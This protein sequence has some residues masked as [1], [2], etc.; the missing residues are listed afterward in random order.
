[1]HRTAAWGGLIK[2]PEEKNEVRRAYKQRLKAE[3]PDEW[4]AFCERRSEHARQ[5]YARKK[6]AGVKFYDSEKRRAYYAANRDRIKAWRSH[7]WKRKQ[8]TDP[9]WCEKEREKRR[10]WDKTHR[11]KRNR[12]PEKAR[13]YRRRSAMKKQNQNPQS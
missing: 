2:T 3:H 7:Y 12:D 6:A 11:P 8:E 4:A 1:M 10:L 5:A 13:E 9:E